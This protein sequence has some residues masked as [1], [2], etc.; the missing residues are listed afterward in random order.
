MKLKHFYGKKKIKY[1]LKCYKNVFDQEHEIKV[2]KNKIR[3]CSKYFQ[4]I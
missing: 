4:N 2:F 3:N 1:L